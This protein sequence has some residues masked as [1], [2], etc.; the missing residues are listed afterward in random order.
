LS[1]LLISDANI[2]IDLEDGCLLAEL[3]KLPF[4]F[5][6]PDLLFVDELEADHGYLIGYGLQLGELSPESMVVKGLTNHSQWLASPG[7]NLSAVLSKT[8][9]K[10]YVANLHWLQNRI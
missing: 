9:L 7:R 2:L 8:P 3:F 6:V 4:Q 1:R 10:Q 5:Q